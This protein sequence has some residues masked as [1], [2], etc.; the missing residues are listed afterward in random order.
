MGGRPSTSVAPFGRNWVSPITRILH[1]ADYAYW[2]G[3]FVRAASVIFFA[4]QLLHLGPRLQVLPWAPA[5]H[6]ARPSSMLYSMK[7]L[8]VV[9]AIAATIFHLA[10]PI[11]LQFLSREDFSRRRPVW[12]ALTA[13]GFASPKFGSIHLSPLQCSYGPVVRTL[14]R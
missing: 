5:Q 4:E 11:A 2:I 14:I 6:N 10:K 9:L 8:I 7:A 13:V 3:H 1:M 12:F